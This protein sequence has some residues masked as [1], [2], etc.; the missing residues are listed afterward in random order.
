MDGRSRDR[1]AGFTASCSGNDP[2]LSPTPIPSPSPPSI[3]PLLGFSFSW[4]DD[5]TIHPRWISPSPRPARLTIFS[6]RS[7]FFRIHRHSYH[8]H[9]RSLDV[10]FGGRRAFPRR[11]G[12]IH[13]FARVSSYARVLG[14]PYRP[15]L[16]AGGLLTRPHSSPSSCPSNTHALSISVTYL[17][18]PIVAHP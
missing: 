18:H 8:V 16:L 5:V 10:L 6:N 9:R 12:S 4:P 13:P 11:S 15:V 14:S 3:S 1:I 17:T 2:S 7:A